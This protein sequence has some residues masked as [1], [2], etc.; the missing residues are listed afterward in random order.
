MGPDRYARSGQARVP[1]VPGRSPRCPDVP[2]DGEDLE[3]PLAIAQYQIK[4]ANGTPRSVP[5]EKAKP[6]R[7]RWWAD[8]QVDVWL[9]APRSPRGSAPTLRG[10]AVS[11]T[12]AQPA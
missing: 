3:D 4:K 8:D 1:A 9:K 10:R 11:F 6:A 7:K 12:Q 5:H 2:L